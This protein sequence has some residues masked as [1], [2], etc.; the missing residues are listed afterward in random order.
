MAVRIVKDI[1][2]DECGSD[3]GVRSYRV[4]VVGDGRGVSPDLCPEHATRLDE[5]IAT[6]P[7][8][9]ASRLRKPPTV[10]TVAEVNK[11]K[12]KRVSAAK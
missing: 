12:R 9:N 1:V 10:R 4:G 11:Q 2:C 6:A 7:Q 8:R 3:V 5:L